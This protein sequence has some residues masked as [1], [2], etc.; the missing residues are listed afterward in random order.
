[1]SKLKQLKDEFFNNP[2]FTLKEQLGY[3]GGTFGNAM[4][5]DTVYTYSDKFSR[6][7]LGISADNLILAGN[8][9]SGINIATPVAAGAVNNIRPRPGRASMTSRMLKITP[10]PF[11]V[12]SL[13]LF[14]VPSGSPA[15]NFVWAFFL[16]ILFRIVDTFFDVSLTTI[17]LRMTANPKDR[18]NFY[19]FAQLAQ[20]LGS[21]L[22]G[23]IL[24]I[25][26]G[27]F[28][29]AAQKQWAYFFITLGFSLLGVAGMFAPAFTLKEKVGAM[30]EED[31]EKNSRAKLNRET[32]VAVLRNRPLM[33]LLL[34]SVFEA[35]R[36]VT[37]ETLPFLYE[38]TLGNMGMKAIVDMISG[39]L[40]YVGLLLV[41]ILGERLSS[42]SLMITGYTWTGACYV[43]MSFLHIGFTVERVRKFRWVIGALIGL[44]GMPNAAMSAT[45]RIVMADSTD[46]ME[47]Y[48]F[49]RYG[50]ALRSDG[51]IVAVKSLVGNF[52]G[53]LRTNIYNIAFKLIGY[54][55]GTGGEN[56]AQTDSTLHGI[57][58]ICTVCSLIGNFVPALI[59]LFNNFTGKKRDQILKELE[60]LRGNAQAEEPAAAG[61]EQ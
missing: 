10:L 30:L 50:S 37:Y 51:T 53:F 29:E 59:F 24:P 20:T 54:K 55:S 35:V 12:F 56:L 9:I 7:F 46:Y 4:G 8:V 21:M 36:K 57:F 45:D 15:F 40:S 2:S 58:S 38:N 48:S 42:R 27:R 11:A 6:D 22:P 60:E 34:S 26:V 23:W 61:Q 49:K 1:M 16:G 18:K 52:N 28:D 47:W 32:A 17:S 39:S 3:A 33:V 5:Q 19:S 41:P 14:I 44:A 43:L 25:I 13:L 31:E